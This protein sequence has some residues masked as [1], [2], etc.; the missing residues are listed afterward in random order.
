MNIFLGMILFLQVFALLQNML[1]HRKMLQTIKRQEKQIEEFLKQIQEE[2]KKETEG[3]VFKNQKV[4]EN[5]NLEGGQVYP[6]EETQKTAQEALINEV[7]SEVF[8]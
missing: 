2:K 4:G 5:Y 3:E 8:S 6:T 1:A 7:L